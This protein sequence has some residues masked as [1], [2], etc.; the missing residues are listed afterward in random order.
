MKRSLDSESTV[1]LSK[2]KGPHT[3]KAQKPKPVLKEM[4]PGLKQ[5]PKIFKQLKPLPKHKEREVPSIK[6]FSISDRNA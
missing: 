3:A 4:P 5:K 6:F 1:L 2:V